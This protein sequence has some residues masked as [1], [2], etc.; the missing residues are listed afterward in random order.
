MGDF[1][2]PVYLTDHRYKDYHFDPT[3][4]EPAN[5]TTGT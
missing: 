5:E 2:H 4:D 1:F 3:I